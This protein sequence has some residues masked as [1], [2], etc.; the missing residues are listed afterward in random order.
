MNTAARITIEAR[1]LLEQRGLDA[2]T[3][4]RIAQAVGVSATAIY[5]HFPDR[6]ALLAVLADQGFKELAEQFDGVYRARRRASTQLLK[7]ADICVDFAIAHSNLYELMFLK[8]RSGARRY[9]QDFKAGRSPTGNV[10]ARSMQELLG[11][12]GS[13]MGWQPVFEVG[14]LSHGLVMLY[15]GGR[16]DATVP[17]FR[18][19]HRRALWRY[20]NAFSK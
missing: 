17:K 8:Q 20:L 4:R 14:A 15:L 7:M 19:L 12:E 5:R 13:R 1:R 18:A 3:M 6:S 11:E 9:P 10:I 2:V 16:I